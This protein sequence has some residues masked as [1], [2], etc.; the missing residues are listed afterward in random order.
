MSKVLR[1]LLLC[2]GAFICVCTICVA[3]LS[4]YNFGN[5]ISLCAGVLLILYSMLLPKIKAKALKIVCNTAIFAFALM[6]AFLSVYGNIDTVKYNED[7]VIVLGAGINGERITLP[8][9]HRLTAAAGYYKKNPGAYIV[10]SGGQG[11]GESITEAEAM[12][13][14]LVENGIPE[15]KIIKEDNSATTRENF[16]LS[17]KILDKKFGSE[18]KVCYITNSFHIY[19]AGL[20]ARRNG[21][22][23]THLHGTTDWYTVPS[24]YIREC[25]AVLFSWFVYR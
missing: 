23:S 10:V 25:A 14:F 3:L 18:Y 16:K 7:A 12:Q 13:R 9:Y 6:I 17:K 8:L 2:A 15:E 1:I 11:A 19:R 5:V 24:N 4:N 22:K 21:L 20:I